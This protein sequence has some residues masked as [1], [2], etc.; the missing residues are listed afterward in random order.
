M[1][2]I[3]YQ[4]QHSVE[5]EARQS[6]HHGGP[7]FDVAAR[8]ALTSLAN[9]GGASP[10]AY[11]IDTPLDRATWFLRMAVRRAIG[12]PNEA[13]PSASYCGAPTP[14]HTCLR[15]GRVSGST[16]AGGMERIGRATARLKPR[17]K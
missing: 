17:E 9:T 4:L 10:K 6:L 13:S 7:G 5:V 12:T 15:F 11:I 2:E 14:R 16:L 3:A 1:D 8:A